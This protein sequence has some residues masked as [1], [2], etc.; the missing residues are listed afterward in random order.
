MSASSASSGSA[1]MRWRSLPARPLSGFARRLRPA[2]PVGLLGAPWS[3][4]GSS[5]LV[6]GIPTLRCATTISPSP[7]RHRRHHPAAGAELGIAHRRLA[8][9]H[10]S[11]PRPL[12]NLFDAIASAA[13]LFFLAMIAGIIG[14]A[15]WALERMVRSPWGRVLR[16]IRED[17]TAASSLGKNAFS[18]RLQAFVHRLDADG[19][20]RRA[21]RQFHR[22][23]QPRRRRCRLSP[24]SSG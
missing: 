7:L 2:V 15:Y 20:G 10:V 16:A 6:V 9:P 22:L 24:S 5:A 4:P 19:S 14:V 1:P 17:E 18:F 11:I 3:R 13:N 8:R 21:L 12:A 23:R